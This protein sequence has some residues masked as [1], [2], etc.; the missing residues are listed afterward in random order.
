M[1]AYNGVMH[2]GVNL[3]KC[4]SCGRPTCK[5]TGIFAHSPQEE[6]TRK[7][8]QK[9]ISNKKAAIRRPSIHF[10]I[11]L[12]GWESSNRINCRLGARIRHPLRNGIGPSPEE[13][14]DKH[15]KRSS[16]TR[17]QDLKHG[18]SPWL[19]EN[20]RQVQDPKQAWSYLKSRCHPQCHSRNHSKQSVFRLIPC[21]KCAYERKRPS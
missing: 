2:K 7:K 3:R 13:K 21:K 17:Q 15:K 16:R 14:R 12:Q 6:S 9:R 20:I 8:R 11:T 4:R 18:D 5:F 10:R 19:T 1:I